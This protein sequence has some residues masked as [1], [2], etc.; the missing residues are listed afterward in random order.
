MTDTVHVQNEDATQLTASNLA[1]YLNTTGWTLVQDGQALQSWMFGSVPTSDHILQLPKDDSFADYQSNLHRAMRQ[2]EQLNGWDAQQLSTHVLGARSDILYIRAS[3]FSTDG[4]IPV[5]EAQRLIDGAVEMV[6][7]A[8]RA[9]YEPRRSFA[10]RPPTRVKDFIA[11]DLRMGHTQRGSFVITI[12]TRLDEQDADAT[13]PEDDAVPNSASLGIAHQPLQRGYI[14][15]FQ[16]QVMRTL[17]SGLT[18][19]KTAMDTALSAP[20]GAA[21][22]NLEEAVQRGVSSQLCQ[23]LGD[24]TEQVGV[25]ALDLSF[26]WAPAEPSPPPRVDDLTFDRPMVSVLTSLRERLTLTAPAEREVEVTGF[27]TRLE[28][29]QDAEEGTVT[30]MG[31]TDTAEQ[32]QVRVALDGDAYTRAVQAHDRRQQVRV[33]GRLVREGNSYYLKGPVTLKRVTVTETHD[34]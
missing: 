14:P 9:T 10:G 7:A 17:A 11:D 2:L 15:P 20:D 8:A 5:R 24:M 16:R 29:G 28:R 31:F 1:T 23:A 3:Q 34:S 19:V 21:A 6:T 26:S 13:G 25:Q 4:T 18:Y 33:S 30:V 27:V 12:L 22:I 32:R